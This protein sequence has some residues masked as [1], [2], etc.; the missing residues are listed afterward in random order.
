MICPSKSPVSTGYTT[1][2]QLTLIHYVKSARN[3][4]WSSAVFSSRCVTHSRKKEESLFQSDLFQICSK[5]RWR[6]GREVRIGRVFTDYPRGGGNGKHRHLNWT[7]WSRE[8]RGLMKISKRK[9]QSFHHGR[10]KL[11]GA[12]IFKV[13]EQ[14]S[15]SLKTQQIFFRFDRPIGRSRLNSRLFRGKGKILFLISALLYPFD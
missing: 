13:G 9:Y 7:C 14:G 11:V 15:R 10:V 4:G 1:L 8:L 5:D 3:F 12:C 6:V 2:H